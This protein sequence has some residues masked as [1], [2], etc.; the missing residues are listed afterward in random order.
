MK[1]LIVF[2]IINVLLANLL[3]SEIYVQTLKGRIVDKDTEFTLIGATVVVQETDPLIGAVADLNGNFKL[4]GVPVGRQSLKASYVGYK[5]R[6][7]NNISLNSGKETVLTIAL[8]Q[9]V[10]EGEEIVVK[11]TAKRTGH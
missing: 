2:L 7:I 5:P 4:E 9:N 3:G 8:E 10:I 1:K 11:A 6:V